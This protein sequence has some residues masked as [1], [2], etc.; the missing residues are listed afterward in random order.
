MFPHSAHEAPTAMKYSGS[1]SRPPHQAYWVAC[2][3][4][5]AKVAAGSGCGWR[6]FTMITLPTVNAG[7][8]GTAGR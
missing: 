1:M 6:R 2:R 8:T 5:W 4:S 3:A 7:A